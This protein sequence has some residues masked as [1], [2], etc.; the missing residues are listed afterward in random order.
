MK[1]KLLIV[2]SP[3]KAKTIKKFLGKDYEVAS[4]FGHIAD[5]PEHELGI[6]IGQS[7]KPKY[8]IAPGKKKV[9]QQL[10]N[11][12]G[13]VDEVYLASDEDREG[14][15][16][17]WHLKNFLNLDD[18]A[19]RIVF[20][21]IT[22]KAIKNALENPRDIDE[23]L[24]NAQQARR[25][26]DRLVGYKL[27]PVLWKKI[28]KG[29]SAGRVQSVALR[30]IVEKEKE[31]Q[32]FKPDISFKVEGL[33]KKKNTDET[34]TAPLD[35]EFKEEEKL[36]EFFN[37]LS[38]KK[39][40]VEN[41]KKKK[42]K[43]N[44]SAPFTTST[45][46]Q[47]AAAKLGFSVSKTM[48][49]AQYL[50]ENGFIT[51]MRTD[52]VHLA[53]TAIEQAKEYILQHF[54]EKYA[55]PKQYK[56]KSKTAQEAHE[57]IR[58]TNIFLEQPSLDRDAARLYK[59]IW[60]RTVASQMAP[61]EIDFTHANIAV[62]PSSYLFKAKGEVLVFDGFLKIYQPA[63][64]ENKEKQL[65]PLKKGE[66]LDALKIIAKQKYTRAPVRYNEAS[67]VKKLEELGIGRPS[68]YAP[69]ISIIQKRGYVE[70]KNI[71]SKKRKIKTL[72]WED[73]K[74]KEKTV[75]ESYGGEK[76]KLFPTDIGTIVNEF[77]IKNFENIMDYGFTAQVETK[78][79]KIARGKYNWVKMLNE[80]Y[81]EFSPHVDQVLR[82][83]KREKGERY[84]GIDPATGKKV[85]AKYG[86]YG[87]MVQLGEG[88]DEKP[89]YASLLPGMSIMDISL[90]EA[91]QLLS[92]PKNIG[93]YEGEP[94][95][96]GSGKYG[97]YVR[98]KNKFISIP[99]HL[100]P[101]RLSLNDAIN[102]IDKKNKAAEPVAYVEN[103]P[104]YVMSGKYGP[105]LK[106]NEMNIK[107]PSN[108]SPATLTEEE[109]KNL[110]EKRKEKD[111]QNTVKEWKNEGISIR[112]GGW[113]RYY[114]YV[115]G[116]RAKI[117][118]KNTNVENL[119]LE[120]I[121]SILSDVA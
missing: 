56:T 80:F 64:D 36:I 107:I 106:W 50:Y 119:T 30:L 2:E 51:Y 79:D 12:T 8:V 99:K 108:L 67:L 52:S 32:N 81:K 6:D 47:E 15:A 16:I 90:E 13:K 9:I 20:H 114:I 46:Q 60:Q 92:L 66:E 55:R 120:D 5:L 21:E 58:P 112:K 105:Y 33:F 86:P 94:V 70:K 61:A 22:E 57:A 109:I 59:L 38:G 63:G 98:Y 24:V 45:L 121:K 83:A 17:A 25:L 111:K 28:K 69:T 35:R 117:L 72:E 34:F 27:S 75:S 73:G 115:K 49:V 4:S 23:N 71:P 11:L 118:P 37:A 44:P 39:F 53:D 96:I 77:L 103:K 68:T 116:K 82:E 100:N 91:L 110:I 97:P 26:L 88:G 7:F 29:L 43:R 41:V 87:P 19:K 95:I 93:E 104:V 48:Q 85:F 84:L 10:K 42:G 102:L 54:G 74:I 18:K 40:I 113:G 1:K 65:P 14:E 78:F 62:H 31:I 89:R 3:A 101:L 76:R